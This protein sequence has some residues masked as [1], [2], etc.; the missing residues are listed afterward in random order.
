MA[1]V[2]KE[3]GY[4]GTVKVR[5]FW[6]EALGKEYLSKKTDFDIESWLRARE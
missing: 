4:S 2:L 5:G 1:E 6:R 3:S